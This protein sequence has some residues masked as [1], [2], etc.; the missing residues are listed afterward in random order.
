[1]H[2]TLVLIKVQTRTYLWYKL[3]FTPPCYKHETVIMELQKANIN[4]DYVH[5]YCDINRCI[6]DHSI[7][8]ILII[9]L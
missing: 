3:L 9:I 4:T 6:K 7:N 1:M 2:I 5:S 8:I